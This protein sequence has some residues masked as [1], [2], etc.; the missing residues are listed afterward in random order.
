MEIE[1]DKTYWLDTNHPNYERWRRSRENSIERGRF[2]ELVISNEIKCENLSILDLG[3]GEGGTSKVL[4]KKNN[5]ISFDISKARLLRQQYPD[6]KLNYICGSTSFLPFQEKLFDVIILQD[7]LEH[8]DERE[9][10]VDNLFNL[11]N[12]NGVIYVSTPNKLSLLNFVSDPHWGVPFISLMKRDNIK[13]YFLKTFRKSERNR[14]D[15]AELLSLNALLRL[16]EKRFEIKLFTKTAVNE[17]F[18]GNKGIAWS[19][20]H[21]KLIK[22]SN[23]LRFSKIIVKLSNNKFGFLNKYLTPTFYFILK[24]KSN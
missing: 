7:V 14:K 12:E 18:K 6:A 23:W 9:K 17:L 1:T 10:L 21:L 5:V 13:K 8:L 20:F 4:S 22:F 24:K 11:L 16:L 3:S 2:V 15:I 19:K